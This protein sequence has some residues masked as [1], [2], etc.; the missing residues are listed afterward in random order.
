MS[1][2]QSCVPFSDETGIPRGGSSKRIVFR[3][4]APGDISLS[5]SKNL[6]QAAPAEAIK[7]CAITLVMM[8]ASFF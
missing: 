4:Y 5:L 7:F 1:C 8:Q 2:T 6:H 3:L